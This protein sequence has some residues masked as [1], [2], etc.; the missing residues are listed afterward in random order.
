MSTYWDT[1][2]IINAVVSPK[3]S[4]RLST[5]EHYTRLHS[6]SEFFAIMTTRGIQAKDLDGSLNRVVLSQTSVATWL[7]KFS[8]R[9]KLMELNLEETLTAFDEAAAKSVQ[10]GKVYDFGHALA[11][12]EA[13]SAQLLTRNTKHFDGLTQNAKVEWP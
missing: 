10:G 1:S 11:A 8:G 4:A 2:A 6:F 7:R 3:V 5:G 13:G 12:D 9:V